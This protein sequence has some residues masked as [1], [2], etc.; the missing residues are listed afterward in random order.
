MRQPIRLLP[1]AL[2]S[3]VILLAAG[4]VVAAAKSPPKHKKAVKLDLC[5]IAGGP[6]A[7]AEVSAPCVQSKTTTTH[8]KKNPL[9]GSSGLVLYGAHW[10]QPSSGGAPQHYAAIIVYHVLG[11]GA[12]L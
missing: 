1:A 3:V 9:G 8:V 5:S 10:G 4:P 11:S 6:V 12:G 7:S 2:G